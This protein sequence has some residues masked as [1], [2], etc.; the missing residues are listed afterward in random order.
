MGADIHLFIEFKQGDSPWETDKN[1]RMLLEDPEYS[2]LQDADAAHRDYNVFAALAG[3]RGDGPDPV[4]LPN[5]VSEKI[6][7]ES[8]RWD[9]DGHSHSY[10]FLEEFE[11][12]I[13]SVYPDAPKNV[14][15]CAFVDRNRFILSRE[16]GYDSLIDYCK[17]E[18]TRF[19]LELAAESMLLDQPIN[20]EVL[21]RLVYWFDN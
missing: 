10:D 15:P 13:R 20:T 21:C 16:L 18:V 12:K 11:L 8:D 14:I 2:Y 9:S 6:Q 19:H 17:N 7:K 4:G 1:H 3:V 5:D